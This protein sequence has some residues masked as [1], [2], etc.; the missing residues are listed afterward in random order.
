MVEGVMSPD[1][2]LVALHTSLDARYRPESVALL[3]WYCL[4]DV[5]GEA[6]RSRL[7]RVARAAGRWNG[8]SSMTEDFARPVDGSRQVAAISRLFGVESGVDADAPAS[9]LA[10]ARSVGAEIGFDPYWTDFLTHRLNRQARAAAGIEISKRQY[11]RRFR[12]LQRLT[13]KADKLSREQDKR[14]LT[15]V[16]RSG[17]AAEITLGRFRADPN[18]ACFVAYYTANRKLRRAFTLSG[19]D[20][21]FDEIAELLFARCRNNPDTNWWMVAQAYATREVL[22]QLTDDQRGQL[23]GRWS[24]VMRRTG[25]MLESVWSA[26][27]FD[28]VGMVVRRGNDSSTWNLLCGAYNT[29]RAAWLSCLTA[30]GA[31]GLLE[32]SC[33]GKR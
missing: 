8:L 22:D 29:A 27:E 2:A 10:F 24:A 31:D 32:I 12:A 1:E 9:L 19:R 16:A 3:A 30:S 25:Q 20:N 26:S 15:L 6:E 4:K 23:L 33:P 18:A 28:R 11:N 5:L 7:A 14:H 21:P 17:F 13:A